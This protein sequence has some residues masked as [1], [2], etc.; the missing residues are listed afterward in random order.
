MITLQ[1]SNNNNKYIELFKKAQNLLNKIWDDRIKNTSSSIYSTPDADDSQPI[2]FSTENEIPENYN[3]TVNNIDY[4]VPPEALKEIFGVENTEYVGISSTTYDDG[5]ETTFDIDTLGEYFSLLS[6]LALIHPQFA[7]LPLDSDELMFDIDLNKRSI[8]IPSGD[9]VYAVVGDHV[10]ETI[11]FKCPR[12]FDAVDLADDA[13]KIIIQTTSINKDGTSKNYIFDAIYKDID[14]ISDNIVFGWPIANYITES[15]NAI[16]FSIRFYSGGDTGLSYSLGTQPATIKVLNGFDFENKNVQLVKP[17]LKNYDI[18]GTTTIDTPTFLKFTTKYEGDQ[19]AH[20]VTLSVEAQSN[21]GKL[22]Y[23]WYYYENNK[24]D[25][26]EITSTS[27]KEGIV[28]QS[29]S[30]YNIIEIREDEFENLKNIYSPLYYKT[31]ESE[32]IWASVEEEDDFNPQYIYAIQLLRPELITSRGGTYYCNVIARKGRMTAEATSKDIII[33]KARDISLNDNLLEDDTLKDLITSY[34]PTIWDT[35]TYKYSGNNFARQLL[36]IPV[37]TSIAG[38]FSFVYGANPNS[39]DLNLNNINFAENSAISEYS[40]IKVKQT[41]NY[42]SSVTDDSFTS[43]KFYKPLPDNIILLINNAKPEGNVN[44]LSDLTA[45]NIKIEYPADS[46]SEDHTMKSSDTGLTK[47]LTYNIE[48]AGRTVQNGASQAETLQLI[49][50]NKDI[51]YTITAVHT[52]TDL[53][54][55]TILSNPVKIM[56]VSE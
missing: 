40:T 33:E 31:T 46:D 18:K 52:F 19:T 38:D 50:S 39:I 56:R 28:Y 15:V 24:A 10:A 22:S 2:K 20:P 47:N 26:Q 55:I 21:T 49:N 48:S 44:L 23:N 45:S 16:N 54:N 17:Y 41:L 32:P 6:T 11:Y 4:S 43:L 1:T 12:Y 29:P 25:S 14:S 5:S 53:G 9:K 37:T 30:T 51:L 13:I 8:S 36:D 7:R 34:H 27:T 35:N 42:T 3:C